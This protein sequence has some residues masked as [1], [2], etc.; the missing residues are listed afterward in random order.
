MQLECIYLKAIQEANAALNETIEVV[1]L[2]NSIKNDI[3]K[4]V[5]S[6]RTNIKEDLALIE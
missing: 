1:T 3:L 5:N 4:S 2:A 6:Y